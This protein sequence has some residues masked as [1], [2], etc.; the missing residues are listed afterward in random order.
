MTQLVCLFH[1]TTRVSTLGACSLGDFLTILAAR[2]LAF[3]DT[4]ASCFVP[5][6]WVSF[7]SELRVMSLE[8]DRAVPISL[9]ELPNQLSGHHR[10]EVDVERQLDTIVPDFTI[11]HFCV[12]GLMSVD[13]KK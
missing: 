10:T 2:L 6:C 4:I 7:L 9:A 8:C 3:E 11:S 1:E 13:T 5:K 12:R